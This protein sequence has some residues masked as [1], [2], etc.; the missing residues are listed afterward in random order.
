MTSD[1]FTLAPEVDAWV[2]HVE[3]E[4]GFCGGGRGA[5]TVTSQGK[6]VA[7]TPHMVNREHYVYSEVA[8]NRSCWNACPRF[9]DKAALPHW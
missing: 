1:D 6:V 5:I 7:I 9:A 4:G 3:T 2:I 8:W